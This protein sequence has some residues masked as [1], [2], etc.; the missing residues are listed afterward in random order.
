MEK[1]ANL[2]QVAKEA[3]ASRSYRE[4]MADIRARQQMR[5]HKSPTR[6]EVDAAL[7]SERESWE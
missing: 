7:Y 6:E 3:L 4:L 1:G 5:G 2:N